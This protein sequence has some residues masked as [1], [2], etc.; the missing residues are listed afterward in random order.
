MQTKSIGIRIKILKYCKEKPCSINEIA[1]AV[2]IKRTAINHHLMELVSK[3]WITKIKNY[4]LNGQSWQDAY[5]TIGD[6]DYVDR[7]VIKEYVPLCDTTNW[8]FWL[9]F[10]MGYTDVVPNIN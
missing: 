9:K 2:G 8:D 10:R 3:D 7:E 6:T 1:E 4:K 5:E